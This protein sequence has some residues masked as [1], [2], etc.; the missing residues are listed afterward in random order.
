MYQADTLI[1]I[2]YFYAF[3]FIIMYYFLYIMVNNVHSKYAIYYTKK[4]KTKNK[5]KRKKAR[6][7]T[8]D[9]LPLSQ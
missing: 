1:N 6:N 3:P 5:Q 2:M 7:A 4:T 9:G 8:L